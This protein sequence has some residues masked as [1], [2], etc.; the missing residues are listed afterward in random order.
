M[1][2]IVCWPDHASAAARLFQ[3]C[4]PPLITPTI[5]GRPG[6]RAKVVARGNTTIVGRRAAGCIHYAQSDYDCDR[7]S[8]ELELT[9]GHKAGGIQG[10]E[11]SEAPRLAAVAFVP[12]F[13]RFFELQCM[14]RA[15]VDVWPFLVNSTVPQPAVQ[16][17]SRPAAPPAPLSGVVLI[18]PSKGDT[19]YCCEGSSLSFNKSWDRRICKLVADY[20]SLL[21]TSAY[22][23]TLGGGWFMTRKVGNAQRMAR[24]QLKV[25]TLLGDARLVLACQI[26]LVYS[27]I[28]LG[29][30][31]AARKILIEQMRVAR[32]E[33]GDST[34]ISVVQSAI[35]HNERTATLVQDCNL[36]PV[37]VGRA[38]DSS[39]RGAVSNLE[40]EFYRFRVV[41]EKE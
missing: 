19:S 40:D 23:S 3:A 35:H 7:D 28:Q 31:E 16:S 6:E 39:W 38:D 41:V 34:L 14:V 32:D 25:A 17:Q 29:R 24:R 15:G 13:A 33:L 8:G 30:F 21:I 5:D 11:A 18:M 20:K 2:Y 9:A 22:L 36:A 4:F 10:G 27:Q 1:V 37:L 12:G 26:H